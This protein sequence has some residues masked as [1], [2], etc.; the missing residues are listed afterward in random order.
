MQGHSMEFSQVPHAPA[1][2]NGNAAPAVS[3][4]GLMGEPHGPLFSVAK[5]KDSD[6]AWA[7]SLGGFE[8]EWTLV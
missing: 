8:R 5:S 3:T 1:L 4:F 7:L 6:S 2:L